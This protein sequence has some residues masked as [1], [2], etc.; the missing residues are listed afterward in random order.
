M[1]L[2]HGT[3]EQ[4]STP[5]IIMPNHSLDFGV[6]FYVTTDFLQAQKWANL[7][8]KRFHQQNAFVISFEFD[9]NVLKNSELNCKL[10][11]QADEEWLDFVLSNRT[12]VNFSYIYDIVQGAVANDQVYG[13]ITLFEAGFLNK[14]GLLENLKTWKYTDQLCFHTEKSLSYLKFIKMELV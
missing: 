4:F 3:T 6:G 8:K 13:A 12:N 7:K 2:F 11:T 10:F 5:K 9:E 14:Q 1:K